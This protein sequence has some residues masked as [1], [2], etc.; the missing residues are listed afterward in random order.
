MKIAK[1][2]FGMLRK[3]AKIKD[4]SFGMLRKRTDFLHKLSTDLV[5]QYDTIVLEDLNV[6]GMV[7]NRKLRC[8]QRS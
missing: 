8:M 6:S 5:E 2:S 1:L 7:K 3:H 4:I